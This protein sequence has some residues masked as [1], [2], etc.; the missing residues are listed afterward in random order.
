M[1][2]TPST[3]S[4]RTLVNAYQATLAASDA[5]G[6]YERLTLVASVVD[7]AEAVRH[8][9][10][11]AVPQGDTL[12]APL[13]AF[14]GEIK[15][16]DKL[17]T[18]ARF[19]G[20]WGQK[21]AKKV[22]AT[23][24]TVGVPVAF[25]ALTGAILTF[26]GTVQDTG[27]E[28]G[29]LLAAA[30]SLAIVFAV[31]YPGPAGRIVVQLGGAVARARSPVRPNS[32]SVLISALTGI[33]RDADRVLSDQL[34]PQASAIFPSVNAGKGTPATVRAWTQAAAGLVAVV[35]VVSLFIF[36]VG[37]IQGFNQ[38]FKPTSPFPTFSPPAFP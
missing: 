12:I 14:L 34:W 27:R 8:R 5:L 26:T 18:V 38:N 31:R 24:A 9:L 2:G 35:T 17:A 19:A 23:V 37:L 25:A 4:V 3:S 1:E 36:G 10:V 11:E 33:G 20:T 30:I 7:H 32:S 29:A 15:K 13:D 16:D 28:F 21:A 6:W 22:L